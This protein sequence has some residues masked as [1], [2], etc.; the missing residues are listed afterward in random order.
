MNWN[1]LIYGV[2][3][4]LSLF[5]YLVKGRKVYAGPVEHLNKV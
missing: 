4:L 2:V 1:I 5:Y 3:V